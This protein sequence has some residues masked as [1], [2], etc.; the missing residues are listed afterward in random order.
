MKV[1]GYQVAPAELEAHLL[2]HRSV[3]DVCVVP[4]VDEYSGELPMAYIV[5]SSRAKELVGQDFL[6]ILELKADIAKVTSWLSWSSEHSLTE[7]L[8]CRRREG[9]LQAFGGRR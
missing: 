5:L 1:R 3:A 6:K 7:I 2:L 4:L 8:A 9:S